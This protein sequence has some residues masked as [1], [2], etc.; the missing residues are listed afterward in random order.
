MRNRRTEVGV[1]ASSN[2]SRLDA[3][4]SIHLDVT[5]RGAIGI[6]NRAIRSSRSQVP[7]QPGIFDV[8]EDIE[9]FSAE[10]ESHRLLNSEAL[11]Q[12][13]IEVR[14]M[15]IGEEV[16]WRIA[17]R[18]SRRRTKRG[19]IIAKR[20]ES[21]EGEIRDARPR[22][23]DNVGVGTCRTRTDAVVHA[24]VIC[25]LPVPDAE[26]RSAFDVGNAGPL[27]PP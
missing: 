8:V 21:I 4:R 23:A 14:A 24:G 5:G 27:P 20:P 19:R 25:E 3:T 17:K 18:Q 11:K 13:H 22:V 12:S 2:R 6:A 1:P 26:R 10:L 15:R 7:T 16:S 9:G